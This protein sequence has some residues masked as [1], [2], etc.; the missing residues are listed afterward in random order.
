MCVRDLVLEL[1]DLAPQL[2]DVLPGVGVV[3]LALDQPLLLLEDRFGG[4]CST[5]A[6]VPVA[7]APFKVKAH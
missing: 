3:E 7:C 1:S 5:T 4:T 6:P 2:V